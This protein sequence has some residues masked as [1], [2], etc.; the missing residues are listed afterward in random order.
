MKPNMKLIDYIDNLKKYAIDQI[1]NFKNQI[2]KQN[3]KIIIKNNINSE[4]SEQ[5]YLK[6]LNEIEEDD[7]IKAKKNTIDETG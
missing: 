7:K 2:N 5:E 4:D 1:N 3:K 6:I